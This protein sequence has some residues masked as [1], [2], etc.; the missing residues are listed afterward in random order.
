[1]TDNNVTSEIARD[2][3][4]TRT[5]RISRVMTGIYDGELRKF[6]INSPQFSLLVVISRLGS[7]SRA[8]IGR[9]NNQDRSTLTR[10]LQL[11]LSEGW[12]EEITHEQGGRRRAIVLT[13][14]GKK[15]L[16]D[17]APAWRAAQLQAKDL[18]GKVGV[19]AVKSIADGL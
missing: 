19:T 5:R 4:L 3:L 2:C 12:I 6:A 16:H 11:M 18:L 1:M 13:K 15:L 14:A 10:N 17:A 9:E 7:A 8:E